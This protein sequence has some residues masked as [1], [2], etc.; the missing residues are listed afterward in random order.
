MMLTPQAYLTWRTLA[1]K[2]LPSA[3]VRSL[4]SDSSSPSF[5]IMFDIDGVIVRGRQ[6]LPFA[7]TAFNRLVDE[8]RRF[9][10]PTVFV[11]N[12]GNSMRKK[13]AQQLSEWL[14]V[15]VRGVG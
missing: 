5:G 6:V 7:P 14:Q 2:S 13:K 8:D 12:A 3:G 15:P 11:T 9:R 4:S 1:S 10:V